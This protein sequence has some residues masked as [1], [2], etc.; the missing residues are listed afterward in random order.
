M[1]V[2]IGASKSV[3]AEALRALSQ[4]GQ[5]T[6]DE[7]TFER[8]LFG[9]LLQSANPEIIVRFLDRAAVASL[10]DLVRIARGLDVLTRPT[11]QPTELHEWLDQ[12]RSLG[13][14]AREIVE[15]LL[16]RE[17]DPPFEDLCG[18]VA[19]KTRALDAPAPVGHR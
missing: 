12:V 19:G 17:L 13:A 10:S 1:V 15:P 5:D 4:A 18:D 16:D 6:C 8:A 3:R 11:S 9:H 7:R 2:E 14:E